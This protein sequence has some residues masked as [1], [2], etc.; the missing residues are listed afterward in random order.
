MKSLMNSKIISFPSK[1]LFFLGAASI[2][3]ACGTGLTGTYNLT[4]QGGQF[5]QNPACSQISLS[6]NESGGQITGQ[7]RNSCFTET[8]QGTSSGNGQA[9]VTLMVM[10]GGSANGLGNS[11]TGYYPNSYYPNT[12]SPYTNYGP[13]NNYGS[14]SN[15]Y[16]NSGGMGCTY[17]GLLMVSGNT[18]SG[19]LNPTGNCIGQ[20][21]ITLNGTRN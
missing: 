15:P 6:V 2:L 1:G 11:Q 21:M 13:Y 3:A 5:Q 8:I 7:G 4:Q 14:Y 9:N 17:Q 12:Y 20:G 19:S 10:S 16:M 18:I